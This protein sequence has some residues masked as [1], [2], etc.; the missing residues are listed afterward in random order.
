MT[1]GVDKCFVKK[2]ANCFAGLQGFSPAAEF[3]G[4]QLL[5]SFSPGGGSNR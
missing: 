2:T 3:E 4:A 1:K 5:C